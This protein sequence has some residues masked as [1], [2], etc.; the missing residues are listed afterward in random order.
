MHDDALKELW[1]AQRIES[2]PPLPDAA[3]LAGM[4]ARLKRM[5]RTLF[6]R[7]CRENIAAVFVMAVFGLYFFLFPAPLARVGSAIVVLSGL[8][9][10]AYPFWRKRRVP[11]A[12]PEASLMQSLESELRKVEVEIALLRSVLWWYILPGAVGVLVF[13]AGLNHSRAMPLSVFTLPFTFFIIALDACIYWINQL[14]CDKRLLPLKHELESFLRVD[15]TV[16]A[17]EI[18]RRYLLAKAIMVAFGLLFV[19]SVGYA[20]RQSRPS[21]QPGAPKFND[22]SAFEEGDVAR[23]D[24]WLREQVE[25][26]SYP[27]LSV[28]IVRDGQVVYQNAF[29]FEDIEARRKATPQTS[30]HVASVTKVFTTSLAVLL[31]DRGVIDLDQPVAKYLPKD[32]SISTRPA[33]GATITLRQLASHTSGLPRGIP[34]PVQSVEGRYALEPERLYQHLAAVS[35]ESD[36]G[37]KELYSN[38]G[39]G[40][41]GHAL[42][43][44]AG[45]P[46]DR[47]LKELVCD[48]LHLEGTAIHVDDT[49]R[50]AAGY[51]SS[52]P[53]RP[54]THSYRERLA[55]SGGLVTSAADLAK[56]LSA[57]MKPGVFSPEMLVQLHTPARLP[58]GSAAGTALGWSVRSRPSTGL[59]LNKNGG[60]NNCSAWIGFAPGHGVGVAVLANCGEPGVDEIGYWL[61]ER[62]VRGGLKPAAKQADARVAP[63]TEGRPGSGEPDMSQMLEAIRVKHKLPALA[64]AVVLDGKI[65]AT[66]AVGFRKHGGA[67]PVTVN[68]RFHLGSVTK[69]MTATVAAML[70]EQGRISWTT[71][72]G[73]SFPEL[74]EKLHAE[75]RGVTLEQL[76]AHRGGAPAAP[77][78]DLWGQAWTAAGPPD[79]Q[80]RAFV[81]GILARRPEAKPGSRHIYSNQGYAIAGVMLEKAAGKPWEELLRTLLFQPLGL[82]SAGFG[83]PAAPGEVDQPWGHKKGLFT[84]LEPVPPGPRADNPP[85]IGPAG[86][87]HCSL[88]DLARYAAFHLAGEQGASELLKAASFRKLHTSAG[89]NYALGWVVLERKWAGGRALM[90][91]GSNTMF[92]VVIWMAP[93]RNCAVIVATNVGVD[94][95]FAGCDEAAGKLIQQFFAK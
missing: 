74:G 52:L 47:L 8:V 89:D 5:D 39:M 35:L 85:A 69:S 90:H 4:N 70:V 94:A 26:S 65:V 38:L 20:I 33:L 68:D 25:R 76:L 80:R 7:D 12:V 22:I 93:E 64:A 56:F 51:S 37:T 53:R 27:G 63:S 36:P 83:A 1:R 82:T 16:P 44:A 34:G 45:K 3:Q 24:A 61:L 78:R 77:P 23:I 17:P 57:Q 31:H 41:L 42:E 6:W 18:P 60:R 91:N 75:Y 95:A 84:G 66:N 54:V 49:L 14:A 88:P 43:R 10:M 21:E 59:I 50:V 9:V 48:P 86:S 30:Y 72:I 58:D 71:T 81:N 67:E 28:A 19:G 55:P 2:A 40:L 92:Y 29:G 73:E 62:S 32:V 11:K 79:E 46:F 13:V 15:G 87:V